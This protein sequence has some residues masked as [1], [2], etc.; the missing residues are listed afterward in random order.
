MRAR[1]V[2]SY[3]LKKYHNYYRYVKKPPTYTSMHR[4]IKKKLIHLHVDTKNNVDYCLMGYVK[5]KTKKLDTE[6]H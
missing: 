5:L 3:Q 2:L 4:N 1:K 6:C